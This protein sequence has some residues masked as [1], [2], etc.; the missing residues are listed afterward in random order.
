MYARAFVLIASLLPAVAQS[1]ATS[2][3]AI[4][5]LLAAFD[6][7][8]LVA[9]GE[10]HRL[11]QDKE[12]VLSLARTTDFPAKANDIVI[13]FGN[14]RF[15]PLLDRYIAGKHVARDQLRRVWADTTVVNG[16]WEAPV[17]EDFLAGIRERNRHLPARHRLRVL[18]CDPPI[19]WKK[20]R[21]IADAAPHLDRDPFCASVIEHEVIARGRRALIFMGDAHVNRRDLTGRTP[22][23]VVTLVERK[24]P[25]TTFVILTYLGQYKDSAIIEERLGAIPAPSL[26]LLRGTWLGA[27]AA[28]PPKAPTRTRVGGGQAISETVDVSSPPRLDEVAD[29]LLFLCPKRELKRS[30][31][32]PERFTPTELNELERRHQI[33]FGLPLDRGEL[34][35]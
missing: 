35:R 4:P 8:P 5:G 33:L 20:V 16:L 17:Y 14:S 27:L 28:V 30:T 21:N 10:G 12:F 26:S 1:P 31:P 13:E 9:I 34:L 25:G 18:A 19:D 11:V 23:N 22:D 24:Y 7:H 15:Q 3:A 6:Q 29:A 2:S 32:S